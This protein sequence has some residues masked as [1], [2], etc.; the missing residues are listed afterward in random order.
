MVT[1]FVGLR[2]GVPV[3][4]GLGVVI[5]GVMGG[6]VGKGVARKVETAVPQPLGV[7]FQL[8]SWLGQE[9]SVKD[10]A[11]APTIPLVVTAHPDAPIILASKVGLSGSVP[12]V[13]SPPYSPIKT[14]ATERRLAGTS[15]FQLVG[16]FPSLA[17]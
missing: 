8:E 9:S 5:V 10:Q 13:T 3:G 1:V 11:V 12:Q 2:V 14:G 16:V 4:V 6:Q 15:A 7:Q 17:P